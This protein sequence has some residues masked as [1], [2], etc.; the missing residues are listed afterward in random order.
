MKQARTFPLS[1]KLLRSLCALF[2]WIALISGIFG[3]LTGSAI[4]GVVWT[5]L[6][7]LVLIVVIEGRLISRLE[8]KQFPV[9][10]LVLIV[11]VIFLVGV[12]ELI[13]L[14]TLRPALSVSYV[15]DALYSLGMLILG[16]YA[17]L[18]LLRQDR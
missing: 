6:G 11:V 5:G 17:A 15:F 16:G 3:L 18:Q 4:T 1:R 10:S 2:I 7:L 8:Q 9:L 12:S 13:N 14:L